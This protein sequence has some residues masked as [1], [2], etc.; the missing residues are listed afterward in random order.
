M[1]G[2]LNP[3]A[4]ELPLAVNEFEPI[5]WAFPSR[6]LKLVPMAPEA[7]EK[8]PSVDRPKTTK[9]TPKK[10]PNGASPKKP[11]K[12]EDRKSKADKLQII[13]AKGS[14]QVSWTIKDGG[15]ASKSSFRVRVSD[16]G[17]VVLLRF[18][19]EGGKRRER[20]CCYLSSIEWKAAKKGSP[21]D[22]IR[23][24]CDKIE[25]RQGEPGQFDELISKVRAF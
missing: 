12:T 14:G 3:S 8:G 21:Q 25:Q 24:I 19:G 15:K 6:S 16:A 4:E 9:K 20:Y 13:E 23:L 11:S 17:F 1:E 2:P 22:F 5:A 7:T 10:G 18:Q